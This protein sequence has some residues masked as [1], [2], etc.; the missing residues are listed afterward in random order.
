VSSVLLINIYSVSLS[1]RSLS[2]INNVLAI[3]LNG[4]NLYPQNR[5]QKINNIGQMEIANNL[6]T[7]DHVHIFASLTKP[8]GTRNAYL[9]LKKYKRTS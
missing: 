3:E 7:L 5:K 1:P 2:I 8:E 9:P 4:N 6:T